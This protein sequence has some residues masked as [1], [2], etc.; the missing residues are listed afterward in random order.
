MPRQG[1]S[2]VRFH[3][4]FMSGTFFKLSRFFP[5]CSFLRYFA[6]IASRYCTM[7]AAVTGQAFMP[8]Y[9]FT[10]QILEQN[11]WKLLTVDALASSTCSSCAFVVGFL[12]G[13]IAYA[14]T[15]AGMHWNDW[16]HGHL[17]A[18]SAAIMSGAIAHT[19]FQIF[20]SLMINVVDSL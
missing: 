1:F 20:S 16:D 7:S 12:I 19:I 9:R 4:L 6:D 15:W 3:L 17:W 10:R 8:S 11:G 14:I 13:S 5:F 18:V 2:E